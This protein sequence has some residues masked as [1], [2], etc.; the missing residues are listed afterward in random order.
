MLV[1]MWVQ[2]V[3][4]VGAVVGGRGPQGPCHYVGPLL[5]LPDLCYFAV[6]VAVVRCYCYYC[7]PMS[8]IATVLPLLGF[9]I[10]VLIF[11]LV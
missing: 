6:L 9:L 8:A 4:F 1:G 11:V 10:F 3:S 5:A 2:A 7:P